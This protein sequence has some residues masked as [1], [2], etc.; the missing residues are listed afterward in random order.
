MIRSSF[1]STACAAALI[2][3]PAVTWSKGT[4]TK[5][6]L[7]GDDL[8]A[9]IEIT[10]PD[11]LRR[12]SIWN[13]PG[14]QTWNHGKQ[15]PPAWA[16]PSNVE[17]RF[18]DWPLGSVSARPSGLQRVEVTFYVGGTAQSDYR[19][20]DRYVFLYEIDSTQRHGYIYLPRWKNELIVHGVEGGWLHAT[21]AWDEIILPIVAA[22]AAR[23]DAASRGSEHGCAIG[24][25]AITADG[26]IDLHMLDDHDVELRSRWVFQPGDPDYAT[27][28]ARMSDV[29]SGRE[30]R[31]S[32]WPPRS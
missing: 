6:E 14:V 28:K 30:T 26:T 7:R 1:V 27:V 12:F 23:S 3:L 31:V 32:C 9:A 19:D 22:G 17:G 25:G 4:T 21:R 16:D 5:I 24:R 10:D 13:G 2:A 8:S 11:V 29:E 20:A 18:V 15:D